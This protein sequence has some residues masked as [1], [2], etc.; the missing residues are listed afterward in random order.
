MGLDHVR[1]QGPADRQRPGQQGTLPDHACRRSAATSRRRSSA[2]TSRSPRRR[3]CSTPSAAST[4]RSTAG[5]AAASTGRATP[6]AT[7]SSTRSRSSRDLR[8]GGEHGPHAL[9]LSP[10]GKSILVVCGNHTA[11]ARRTS[12]P[13]G[14]RGTGAR[15]IS[16]PASGTP[17][18]T[19]GAS[20]PPAAG[21]PRPT[22]TARPGRSSA[23]A[24]ATPTTWPSTPTASCSS[25]TPTWSG[26][27]GMPWY[28]PTRVVHATSGSE[29]GWRSG[30][31][32]WPT[33]YVDSLPADGRH[34]PRLARRRDLRL[35]HEVPREVPEGP[36][37]LRLDLRHDL[38][39]PPRAGRLDL[40]G[41]E[42]GV[43]LAHAPAA[44]R[45]RR[46]APTAP[47]TSRSAAAGRSR[48]C[49]A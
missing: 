46:S 17:T 22:P 19:P 1:R 37:H 18:A 43:R 32:K 35:R 30:T 2:S 15:T 31:G 48:S 28:R 10:D 24:I 20:W 13:A 45:R 42:G 5:P 27:M 44:D 3:G 26:T 33:Y 34:R 6:T 41:R 38:R 36:V 23:S 40:Q 25:T 21:S 49:S 9:R 29:F 12:T 14:S 39:P 11:P 8:G 4:S 7:T 47:S 16:S